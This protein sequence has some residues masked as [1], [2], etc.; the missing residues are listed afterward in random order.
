M[1]H[2]DQFNIEKWIMHQT[3]WFD[4]FNTSFNTLFY[5][6]SQEVIFNVCFVKGNRIWLLEEN[7][8]GSK[9]SKFQWQS[10]KQK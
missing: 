5:E 8:N 2:Q 9:N 7:K 1:E 4:C 10:M 3:N 6:L